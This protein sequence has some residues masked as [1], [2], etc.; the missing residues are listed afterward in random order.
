M[1]FTPWRQRQQ[2]AMHIGTAPA[3]VPALFHLP[4]QDSFDLW[5]I[6]VP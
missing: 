5:P 3:K 2:L 6:Y 1:G 4:P